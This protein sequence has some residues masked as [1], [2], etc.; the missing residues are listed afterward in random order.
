VHREDV[1]HPAPDPA[2][3]DHWLCP[4]IGYL[5]HEAPGCRTFVGEWTVSEIE[6]YFVRRVTMVP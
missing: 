6:D 3:D 4:G 5:R 2:L 1:V